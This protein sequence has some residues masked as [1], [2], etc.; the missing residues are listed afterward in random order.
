[1]KD[2]SQLVF[3]GTGLT[4][5]LL[6]GDKLTGDSSDAEAVVLLK[7]AP[8]VSAAVNVYIVSGTFDAAET[9]NSEYY[10]G[11]VGDLAGAAHVTASV[12]KVWKPTSTK[13][14][15][16]TTTANWSAD[17]AVGETFTSKILG[18]VEGVFQVI[19][20][21]G[22]TTVAELVFGTMTAGAVLTSATGKTATA[23]GSNQIVALLTPSLSVLVNR[24][25]LA[26]TLFAAH[27]NFTMRSEAGGPGRLEFEVTGKAGAAA[28][29]AFITGTSFA[30]TVAPRLA[31]GIVLLD[32]VAIPVKSLEFT[33]Q[34]DVVMRADG[35]SSQGDHGAELG[36]RDPQSTLELDQAGLAAFDYWTK[37]ENS[38]LAKLAAVFGN[39]PGNRLSLIARRSQISGLSD[40]EAD[41]IATH[42]VTLNH[43]LEASDGD[44][45]FLIAHT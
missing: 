41:Q 37:W 4:Q 20:V 15:T 39:T 38:T 43:R 28:D 26:R 8:A 19:S 1:M 23:A 35:N 31:G 9:I 24:S 27:S 5:P 32:D 44:D 17:P 7:H 22:T 21:A 16:I 45:E 33:P 11:S 25:K 12:G 29:S 3:D 18:I 2:G 42:S 6:P 30:T 14:V 13:S 36:G 40:G 34:N 10:G